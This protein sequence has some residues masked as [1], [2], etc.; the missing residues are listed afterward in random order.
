M[1]IADGNANWYGHYGK[2]YEIFFKNLGIELSHDSAI[3]PLG[4]YPKEI[5][6]GFQKRIGTFVF[7]GALFTRQFCCTAKTQQKTESIMG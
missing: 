5:K 3:T 6:T 2:E 7:I 4:F 1:C